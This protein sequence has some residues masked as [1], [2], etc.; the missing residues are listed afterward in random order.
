MVV[1]EFE[2]ADGRAGAETPTG[3]FMIGAAL[4][5]VAEVGIVYW[6]DRV[7]R[8]WWKANQP[9][10]GSIARVERMRATYG[11]RRANLSEVVQVTGEIFAEVSRALAQAG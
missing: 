8:R 1:S 2:T 6:F 7:H 9:F 5:L 10:A 11:E 4:F 3:M